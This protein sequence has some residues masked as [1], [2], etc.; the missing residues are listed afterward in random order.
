MMVTYAKAIIESMLK[1]VVSSETLENGTIKV[2]IK[3]VTMSVTELETLRK[4]VHAKD[5]K[6][7]LPADNKDGFV[8]RF[9]P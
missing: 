9:I 2:H 8:Y 3:N 6:V 7:G 4:M 5:V 1:G